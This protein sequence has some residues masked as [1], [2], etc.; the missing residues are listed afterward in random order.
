MASSRLLITPGGFGD[1]ARGVA[2]GNGGGV[3]PLAARIGGAGGDTSD[4]YGEL[5]GGTENE[6]TLV[7]RTPISAPP[8]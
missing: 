5:V 7:R 3:V 8:A 6:S 2:V 4:V 1:G